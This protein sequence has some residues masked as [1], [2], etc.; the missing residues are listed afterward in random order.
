VAGSLTGLLAGMM[1]YDA[2]GA[3]SLVMRRDPPPSLR[4]YSEL[5]DTSTLVDPS[6]F[7]AIRAGK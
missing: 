2:T 3:P 5:A 6:V 4:N 7:K 1:S